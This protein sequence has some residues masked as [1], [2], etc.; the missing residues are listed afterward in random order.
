MIRHACVLCLLMFPL[1]C[2]HRIVL[3]AEGATVQTT[4]NADL[5]LECRLL[6]DVSI[7]VPPDAARPRTEEQ[8]LMLMRNKVGQSGGNVL[9]VDSTDARTE[10]ASAYYVGRGRAY[11]CPEQGADTNGPGAER[12][13]ETPEGTTADDSPDAD[14]EGVS[15]DEPD[16]LDL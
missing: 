15:T 9:V 14:G 7:G 1:G 5:A 6:Y 3:T 8:L 4:D 11:R 16:P 13:G 12:A 2:A 10:G